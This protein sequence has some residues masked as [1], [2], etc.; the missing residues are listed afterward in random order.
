VPAL[1]RYLGQKLPS[2]LSGFWIQKPSTVKHRCSQQLF[3]D[4]L[5]FIQR[6]GKKKTC[7]IK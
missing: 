2:W 6:K 3:R 4:E 7:P 1:L 5:P